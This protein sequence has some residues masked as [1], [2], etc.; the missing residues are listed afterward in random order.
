MMKQ[1]P[2]KLPWIYLLLS[3][4]ISWGIWIPAAFT[5]RDYQ[6]SPYLLATVLVGAF[7]PGLAA[8]IVTYINKDK[9]DFQEFRNRIYELRRLRPAWILIILALWPVL[10]AAAIGITSWIGAPIPESPFLTELLAQPNTIPLIIFLYFLQSGVEEVGW[11]GYLQE[12][13]GQIFSLPVS[14]LLVGLVHTIW[15]LPLFW[16]VGTNQI[17]MGFGA[18]FLIFI[19]FVISGSVYS[20]W[21]YYGNNRSVLAAALLHTTANLSFDIFGYAP[22][23]L[24][25]FIYVLLMMAGAVPLLWYLGRHN[26]AGSSHKSSPQA[27]ITP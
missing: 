18:D 22:G 3:F 12:N 21:C 23:T 15:H 25:H 17:K 24:K 13:L 7:G 10:H 5:G 6:S 4:G 11:R 8:I 20:A 9:E 26:K 2:G 19:A 27:D 1:I 14:A 16:I